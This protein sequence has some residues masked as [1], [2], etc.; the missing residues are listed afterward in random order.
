MSKITHKAYINK[1]KVHFNF[2]K[3]LCVDEKETVD[4][5]RQRHMK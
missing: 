3:D 4:E 5:R 2:K 1:N